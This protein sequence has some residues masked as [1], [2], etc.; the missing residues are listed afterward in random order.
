LRTADPTA[1][2]L[3]WILTAPIALAASVLGAV[4]KSRR[5]GELEMLPGVARKLALAFMPA[6]CAGALLTLACWRAGA[7]ALLPPLWLLC[8]GTAVVASGAWSVR[9]VPA[10]GAAFLALGALAVVA[11]PGWGDALLV[12]GFG[13]LHLG[14]GPWIARRHGG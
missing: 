12:I 3:L 11:P 14:F 8:Y 4:W 2:L 1:R 13:G 9:T 6:M 10:M 5:T 7:F